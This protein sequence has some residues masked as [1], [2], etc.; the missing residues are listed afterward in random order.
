MYHHYFAL[1]AW[2][3]DQDPQYITFDYEKFD[4]ASPGSNYWQT[5]LNMFQGLPTA[6]N[7]NNFQ[8]NSVKIYPNPV[9]NNFT[10]ELFS[11]RSEIISIELYNIIGEKAVTI[12]DKQYISSGTSTLHFNLNYL[13]KGIYF[14]RINS[15]NVNIIQKII[16]IE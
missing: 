12:C 4:G 9:I 6:I 2:R 15:V 10:I 11:S 1:W 16:F 13:R 8:Y 7:E 3:D 14:L 5:V